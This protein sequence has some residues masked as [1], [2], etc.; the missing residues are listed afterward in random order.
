MNEYS[1]F[2]SLAPQDEAS[3]VVFERTTRENLHKS[4][5]IAAICSGVFGVVMVAIY[6]AFPPPE[7]KHA[8]DD[9]KAQVKTAKPAAEA[10][11]T[12]DK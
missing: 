5:V 11:P 1:N 6:F 12:P 7:K 3:F 4:F 2:S 9:E 10:A 8:A